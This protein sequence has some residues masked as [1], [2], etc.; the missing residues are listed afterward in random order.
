MPLIFVKGSTCKYCVFFNIFFKDSGLRDLQGHNGVNMKQFCKWV[1]E[2]KSN[3]LI[4]FHEYLN[5]LVEYF[6]YIFVGTSEIKTDGLLK[7][8]FSSTIF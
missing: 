8:K 2:W 4:N 6:V 5:S 3:L 7:W 1:P